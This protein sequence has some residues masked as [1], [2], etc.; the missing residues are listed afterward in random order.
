MLQVRS[1]SSH[2][3]TTRRDTSHLPERLSTHQ[4]EVNTQKTASG[5]IFLSQMRPSKTDVFPKTEHVT[6]IPGNPSR[7]RHSRNGRSWGCCLWSTFLSCLF[8]V[9]ASVS[10]YI[11]LALGCNCGVGILVLPPADTA[12]VS[13]RTLIFVAPSSPSAPPLF[14]LSLPSGFPPRVDRIWQPASCCLC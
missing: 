6:R 13:V 1:G 5:E 8:K 10:V 11:C 12:L 9:C 3:V 14:S 7:V 2:N 4:Q